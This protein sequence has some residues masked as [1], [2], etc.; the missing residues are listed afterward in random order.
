MWFNFCV[1]ASESKAKFFNPNDMHSEKILK[2][3]EG[4]RYILNKYLKTRKDHV[5]NWVH[6]I[7]GYFSLVIVLRFHFD[8]KKKFDY[9]IFASIIEYISYDAVIKP[10]HRH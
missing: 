10:L 7:H 6:T 4:S 3:F 1:D 5:N 2:V 8:S 9:W